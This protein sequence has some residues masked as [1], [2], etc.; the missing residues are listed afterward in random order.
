MRVCPTCQSTYPD[1]ADFCLKDLTPLPPPYAATKEALASSLARRYRIV[2]KLGAGGMG[3]VFL[4]EQITLGNRR[5]ALKVL[6]RKLL[7]DPQFLLRFHDEGVSTARIQ[8]PNVVTIYESGQADD[9]SPYIAMEYLEGEPLRGALRRRGALP[10][11]ECAEILQQAARGLNAAHKLGIIHRDLKP[12]NLFLTRGDEGELIVKIVDFGVAKLR[13]SATHTVTGMVLGTPAYMSYEQASGMRSD[14]LDAR[15]DIYSLGVVTYEM[16]TGRVPFHSDTPLGYVRK[17]MLEEPPPFRAA[18]PGLSFPAQVE[19]V[20]MKALAKDRDQRYGSVLD[21]AREFARA[22]TPPV[23]PAKPLATTRTVEPPIPDAGAVPKPPLRGAGSTLPPTVMPAPRPRDVGPS[24]ARP[25]AEP[26][27][28]PDVEPGAE[29]RS[30]LQAGPQLGTLQRGK[31]S[32]VARVSLAAAGV[33]LIAA[34]LALV[35]WPRPSQAP[36][37]AQEETAAPAKPQAVVP[38]QTANNPPSGPPTQPQTAV[39]KPSV[40]NPPTNPPSPQPN[41]AQIVVQTSPNAQVYLDDTFKGQVSPQGRLVIENPKPGDHSLRVSL[42]GKKNYEGHVT[43]LAGQAASVQATLADLTG[44][45]KLQTSAGAEVLLDNSS[46]GTA[47]AAGQLV[48]QEVVPGRHDLR[49][50]A[51]GKKEFRQTVAVLAGQE[52]TIEARLEDIGPPTGT[53]RENRRDGLNYVWI[54]PG[55]FMMGCSPGDSE[56]FSQEKPAHQVTITRGF[57]IGQTPVTVGAYKRFAG[58]TGRQMPDAPNFNNGW[59]NDNMPIVYVRWDDAQAYCGWMGGRLPT[60]AEWEYAARG[61]NTEA[62][63]GPI[64]EVAWYSNNSGGQ[65]HDVAR[66]RRNGF[67]LYDML[68]N[69]WQWVNDWYD[70]SYYQSSPSQDPA[71]P[72]SG[73]YRVLRGGSWCDSPRVV[74]VSNRIGSCPAGRSD[75]YGFRC[76]GEVE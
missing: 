4:A 63:Y 39:T 75:G 34:V 44:S 68:G 10:V 30:A 18:A 20:V 62:R 64:D 16:L 36:R 15:S 11:D 9:G 27:L 7:D 48:L 37:P 71:G 28:R 5:V 73:Q 23:E 19:A 72:T 74:R 2:K 69:V 31:T 32:R 12:D 1:D 46:R 61:G 50:S 35:Y 22:A 60:E 53:V 65:T 6:S 40:S 3:S 21:F 59:T 42:A 8:H 13:E 67:G 66:K 33:V 41:P 70:E 54:P 43:V 52:A 29:R 24:G 55:T 51:R 25:G 49:V 76:G 14:E 47:D 58:A 56:C 38:A 57:W 45:V 26:G 17:H